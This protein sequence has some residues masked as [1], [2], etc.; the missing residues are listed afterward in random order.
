[1]ELRTPEPDRRWRLHME[2]EDQG[3]RLVG[4]KDELHIILPALQT[5]P[6]ASYD[7]RHLLCLCVVECRVCEWCTQVWLHVYVSWGLCI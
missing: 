5:Y 1:M 6:V 7:P 2:R 3:C 4:T